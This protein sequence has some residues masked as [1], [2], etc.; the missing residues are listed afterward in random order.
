[1]PLNP[2]ALDD[3]SY[4]DILQEMLASIPAHTPEWTSPQPGDPGQTLL[5]LFSWLADSILYRANLIPERQRLAFLKLLGQQLQPAA[6][7]QGIVALIADPSQTAVSHLIAGASLT[8][9][10]NFETLGELDLLPLTAQVYIKA[11]LAGDQKETAK[12]LLSG[13]Q[14]LYG[15]QGQTLAG[16]TTTP[17]FQNNQADADDVALAAATIDQC[18]WFALMAPKAANRDAIRAA[19][20]GKNTS[21]EFLN[22]GF[23]PAL[24]LPDPFADIGPAAAVTATWQMTLNSPLAPNQPAGL[25][26]LNLIDDTTQGLTRPGVVRLAVPQTADI[27]APPNDVR[28]DSQ[29][30]VG[31]KPPRLDTPGI[32]ASL[33]TWVRLSVTSALSVSWAGV[34]AV[35]IDQRA[36]SKL[37]VVGVSDGT[38]RQQFNLAQTQ[39]DPASFILDVDTPGLGYQMWQPTD[40]LAA[41]QGPVPAYVLDPE[42]GTVTFGDQ[43]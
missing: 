38:A 2:P 22:I 6:A 7:A 24:K 25:V 19:I 39:V 30:G 18:L 21:Q 31:P 20:G 10:V 11:P 9:P 42:A 35:A 28:A 12:P 5:E 8:G 37:V 40:D 16:Y 36:T 1:M 17:V 3:R 23:V 34:N 43:L 32:D 26:T 15:L 13:L 41:L 33:V 4:S 14:Q 27:G 29:A